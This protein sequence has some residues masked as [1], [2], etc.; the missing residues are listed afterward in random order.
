MKKDNIK[1]EYNYY[2]DLNYYLSMI[3]KRTKTTK[4]KLAFENLRK[5]LNEVNLKDKIGL[6]YSKEITKILNDTNRLDKDTLETLIK[7]TDEIIKKA[8]ANNT[9]LSKEELTKEIAK[10][11]NNKFDLVYKASRVNAIGRTVATYTS[12]NTKR[13]IADKYKFKLM[14]ISQRDSKV[15]MSHRKAD[16]QKQ[17]DKGMF[18]IGGYETPH[19]AGSGL[20]AKEAVNCR[21]VTRGIRN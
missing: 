9:D 1:V 10:T 18:S 16:G 5:V 4:E 17:N 11:I 3:A 12:E 2:F 7:D 6:D 14:W 13:V 19:P 8:K 21:C 15:R 20:P